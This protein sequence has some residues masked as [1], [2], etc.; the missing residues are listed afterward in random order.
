MKLAV[1]SC[2]GTRGLSLGT[3]LGLPE[4]AGI[5]TAVAPGLCSVTFTHLFAVLLAQQPKLQP[6]QA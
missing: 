3:S 2:T 1:V 5:P 4:P 6:Q